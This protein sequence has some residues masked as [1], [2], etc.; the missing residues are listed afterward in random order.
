MANRRPV[1]G[2]PGRT[3]RVQKRFID[4]GSKLY[5]FLVHNK[6]ERILVGRNI[7]KQY[8]VT[9]FGHYY[10]LGATLQEMLSGGILYLSREHTFVGRQVYDV[11]DVVLDD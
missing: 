5:Q 10:L 8:W 9:S 4:R 2:I 11:Y 7:N 6:I 3:I 1:N